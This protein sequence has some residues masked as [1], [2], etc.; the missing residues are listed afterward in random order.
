MKREK[1]LIFTS[2]SLC[3]EDKGWDQAFWSMASTEEKFLATSELI[4]FAYQVK[5]NKLLPMVVD[6]SFFVSGRLND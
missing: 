3:T 2:G 5:I 1:N 4:R 6:K